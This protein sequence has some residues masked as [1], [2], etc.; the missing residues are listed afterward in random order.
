M[1]R[2]Y[3]EYPLF[4]LDNACKMAIAP[5]PSSSRP[6]CESRS[7]ALDF[8]LPPCFARAA[9]SDISDRP[10]PEE[11]GRD[12]NMSYSTASPTAQ[13][14]FGKMSEPPTTL[15]LLVIGQSGPSSSLGLFPLER[16]LSPRARGMCG[17]FLI[18]SPDKERVGRDQAASSRRLD[19]G[20]ATVSLPPCRLRA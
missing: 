16:P 10:T 11:P 18:G 8:D 9:E 6:T 13:P 1:H 17:V 4:S 5:L 12:P 7:T 2:Y 19:R 3:S 14:S 15:K 20:R